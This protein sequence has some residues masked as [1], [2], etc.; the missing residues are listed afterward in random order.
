[1]LPLSRYRVTGRSMEPN[2]FDGDYVIAFSYIFNKPKIGD[3]IVFKK[4]K[5][6]LIKRI[7][8]AGDIKIVVTGDNSK[9]KFIVYKKDIL[10]KVI[11]RI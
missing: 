3:V 10:G 9:N 2:F 5:M 4:G 1:M 7:E 6:F 8:K 11:S